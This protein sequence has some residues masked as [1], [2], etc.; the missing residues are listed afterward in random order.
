MNPLS[1]DVSTKFAE[2]EEVLA[3]APSLD[4][5]TLVAI[6]NYWEFQC[7]DNLTFDAWMHAHIKKAAAVLKA[8][9]ERT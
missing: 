2:M 8:V 6:H 3:S 5:E 9:E 7:E 4:Y 1:Q